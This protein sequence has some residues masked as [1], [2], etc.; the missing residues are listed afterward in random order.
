[1]EAVFPGDGGA[2]H[3]AVLGALLATGADRTRAD[4]EGKTSVQHANARGYAS[5]AARLMRLN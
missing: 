5:A 4:K 3:Q 1:M 2:D